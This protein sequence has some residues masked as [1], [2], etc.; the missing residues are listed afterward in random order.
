ML[1]RRSGLYLAMPTGQK[2]PQ[3]SAPEEA[4]QGQLLFQS[5]T[6]HFSAPT[7]RGRMQTGRRGKR[8]GP[9]LEEGNSV[10]L[11]NHPLSSL[12]SL[13]SRGS[14]KGPTLNGTSRW[15]S[16]LAFT[17]KQHMNPV[18]QVQ[19]DR[20][21]WHVKYLLTV[22]AVVGRAGKELAHCCPA[23]GPS[24]SGCTTSSPPPA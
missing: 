21:I 16:P 17:N 12:L 3:L 4:Q 19:M 8:G 20:R 18:P 15:F 5:S 2:S 10:H 24:S 6:G 1:I 13:L 14:G 11:L 7:G 23:L 22:A 9:C